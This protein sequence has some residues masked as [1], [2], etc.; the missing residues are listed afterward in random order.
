MENQNSDLKLVIDNLVQILYEMSEAS[1]TCSKPNYYDKFRFGLDEL[2]EAGDY[3]HY[4]ED[5]RILG[6]PRLD[7]DGY[8]ILD[9]EQPQDPLTPDGIYETFVD[10]DV[11]RGDECFLDVN[12]KVEDIKI[13][14]HLWGDIF[15]YQTNVKPYKFI[16]HFQQKSLLDVLVGTIG[17]SAYTN[18]VWAIYKDR[19][20]EEALDASMKKLGH[21]YEQLSLY[22]LDEYLSKKESYYGVNLYH[23]EKHSIAILRA[24]REKGD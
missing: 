15:G 13:V 7:M 17:S 12:I 10:P 5:I 1:A 11:S 6:L 2:E 20:Y 8:S 19:Q 21:W 22:E 4:P 24:E 23:K 16:S 18:L 14:G 3:H 9:T